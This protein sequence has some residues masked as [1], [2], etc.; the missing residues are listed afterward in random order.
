[1]SLPA[2]VGV[3]LA[4]AFLILCLGLITAMAIDVTKRPGGPDRSLSQVGD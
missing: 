4:A 3:A 1:M 2:K